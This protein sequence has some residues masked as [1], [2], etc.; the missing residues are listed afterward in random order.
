MNVESNVPTDPR[1]SLALKLVEP[2]VSAH[3]PWGDD[4]LGRKE[5]AARLTNLIGNQSLPLTISIHGAWGTGKTFMLKRWQ[6]DLQTQEFS[7]IYFNAW[8]DDFCD[9]PLLAILA[10]LADHFKEDRLKK[11]GNL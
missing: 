2:E 3:D 10:Q 8:E 11:L 5:M 1:D 4:V 6:Q 7:A 9:D